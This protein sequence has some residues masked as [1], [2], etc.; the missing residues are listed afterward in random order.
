MVVARV[1]AEHADE[2]G[3]RWPLM[4]FPRS[5]AARSA[6]PAEALRECVR[7]Y[8]PRLGSILFRGFGV[9]DPPAFRRWVAAFGAPVLEPWGSSCVLGTEAAVPGSGAP[10]PG[11]VLHQAYAHT[12]RWPAKLW[13]HCPAA[14]GP[15]S[16]QLADGRDIWQRLPEGAR[17]LFSE[18]ELVYEYE[19]QT[20]ASK[21]EPLLV[22]L[23]ARGLR[24]EP[25]PA[26]ISASQSGPVVLADAVTAELSW[27]NQVHLF[28]SPQ[29]E[30]PGTLRWC[31]AAGRRWSASVRLADGSGIDRALLAQVHE[32]VER[33]R[34]VVPWEPGDVL[35]LDNQLTAHGWQAAPG[36]HHAPAAALTEPRS[37][38]VRSAAGEPRAH[39]PG[40]EPGC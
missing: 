19:L 22:R 12:P 35:L 2:P 26:G 15:E 5:L 21:L 1:D 33:S 14:H 23:R 25:T 18:R 4:V 32:A 38:S 8:L 11:G 31:D 30:A 29:L 37:Y 40:E 36:Q 3:M 7:R 24:C 27:F 39:H 20:G 13:L 17:R 6:P 9:L 34:F 28:A 10:A 16:L